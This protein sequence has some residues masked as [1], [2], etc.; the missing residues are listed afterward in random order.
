LAR[1]K[2]SV[3]AEAVRFLQLHREEAMRQLKPE[4]HHYLDDRIGVSNWYPETEYLALIRVIATLIPT[5]IPTSAGDPYGTMGRIAAR[6]HM[7]KIYSH[8]INE[9]DE[10]A[11][12]RRG[13]VLWQTMHD[14]GQ[15]TMKLEAPGQARL[16]LI[17]YAIPNRETCELTT[18]YIHEVF[19]IAGLKDPAVVM[20]DCRVSGG[21]ICSW[22]ATWRPK[23][24]G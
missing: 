15:M 18:G 6:Q 4:L 12:V 3:I 17:H 1:I 14:T 19:K 23:E 20:T 22:R 24:R 8:L 10:L 11:L 13:F 9:S 5:L 7:K 16:D 21:E 2:G